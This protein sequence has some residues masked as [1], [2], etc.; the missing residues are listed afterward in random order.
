MI[1]FWSVLMITI[2]SNIHIV[3]LGLMRGD[4]E[5]GLFAAAWK[6]FNF[7]IVLP[8]PIGTLFLPRIANLTRQPGERIR[9]TTIYIRTIVVVAVPMTVFGTAA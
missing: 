2:T 8:N 7:A 5:L 1:Y 4:T 9:T 3:L 6:P